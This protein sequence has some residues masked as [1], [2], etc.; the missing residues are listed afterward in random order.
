MLS[1]PPNNLRNPSREPATNQRPRR[2][3]KLLHP[4][5]RGSKRPSRPIHSPNSP[6]QPLPQRL[7][8]PLK[9]DR[10]TPKIS[11]PPQ[12]LRPR[13]HR[14]QT[15]PPTTDTMRAIHLNNHVP[16]LK[17]PPTKPRTQ[18]ATQN[19]TA[20][21]TSTHPDIKQIITPGSPRLS[22]SAEIPVIR[23]GKHRVGEKRLQGLVKRKPSPLRTTGPG[24]DPTIGPNRPRHSDADRP[25]RHVETS[26]QRVHMRGELGKVTGRAVPRRPR[27]SGLV[28]AASVGLDSEG[29]LGAADVDAQEVRRF[30]ATQRPGNDGQK[31]SRSAGCR[32]TTSG[33]A[34]SSS[35]TS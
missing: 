32:S 2:M 16:D 1:H 6:R 23:T 34:A 19:K 20:T 13:S 7:P 11:R 15:P 3:N 31:A 4:S 10:S 22:E 30:H 29:Y 12:R 21:N 17:G 27:E 14:L 28:D 8:Q 5:H 33:P 26:P 24:S 9:T 35:S 25:Q 18:R